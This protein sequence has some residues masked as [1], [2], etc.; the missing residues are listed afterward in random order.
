[1][2]CGLE[3]LEDA[4]Y[5]IFAV[6][7]IFLRDFLSVGGPSHVCRGSPG[8]RWQIA[9]GSVG[10]ECWNVTKRRRTRLEGLFS[11]RVGA[12]GCCLISL[13]QIGTDLLGA[14]WDGERGTQE[15]RFRLGLV[16]GFPLSFWAGRWNLLW[17][18]WFSRG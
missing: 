13:L 7:H 4:G 18:G 6:P 15:P 2:K 1:M 8:V 17:R 11:F 14:A 16:I 5:L 3:P 9:R 12:S 10:E